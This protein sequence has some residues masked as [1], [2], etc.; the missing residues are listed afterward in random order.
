MTDMIEKVARAIYASHPFNNNHDS[1][2]PGFD[3]LSPAWR[4]VMFMNARAAIEAMR[5][6]T[7]EMIEAGNYAIDEH[8][9]FWN[10]D[11]GAGYSVGSTAAV[12]AI[13]AMIDAALSD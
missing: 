5:K 11:S 4:E 3:G 2:N 1:L 6:P 9:D 8:I 13:N 7:P 10:Y 12:A